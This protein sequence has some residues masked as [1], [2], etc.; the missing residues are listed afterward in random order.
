MIDSLIQR[1]RA[2]MAEIPQ[3]AVERVSRALNNTDSSSCTGPSKPCP[4]SVSSAIGHVL[5]GATYEGTTSLVLPCG[6]R[7]ADTI[8]FLGGQSSEELPGALPL[9]PLPFPD[10]S[11]DSVF[12][13]MEAAH[14]RCPELSRSRSATPLRLLLKECVRVLKPGGCLVLTAPNRNS[15]WR[16]LRSATNPLQPKPQ[17]PARTKGGYTRLLHSAGFSGVEHYI[18]WPDPSAWRQLI[19]VDNFIGHA[20]FR[21]PGTALKQKVGKAMFMLL[22]RLGFAAEFVA[23]YCII[24]IKPVVD[25]AFDALPSTLDL[26][27][28]SAGTRG[29]SS[30]S[31]LDF[32]GSSN[33]IVFKVD[34]RFFKVP[35]SSGSAT[36]L[37][38]EAEMVA[39]A[40]ELDPALSTL[41]LPSEF[42]SVAGAGFAVFPHIQLH[43]TGSWDE[44]VER[45]SYALERLALE[46][47]P[48]PLSETD[49]W[50]RLF[51]EEMLQDFAALGAG[52]LLAD[53]QRRSAM[54]TAPAGIVHGDLVYHNVICDKRD[55]RLF[56][57]DWSQG[58]RHSPKFL[59][60]VRA[61]YAIARRQY[62]SRNHGKTNSEEILGAWNL[63]VAGEPGNPLY[64]Y[65]EAASGE[66]TWKE[67]LAVAFLDR[68][69]RDLWA[70]RSNEGFRSPV[71][72]MLRTRLDLVRHCLQVPHLRSP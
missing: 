70:L 28:R 30:I 26:I 8:H 36:L 13:D 50:R 20:D 63:L 31:H 43:Y 46:G 17:P 47:R 9:R 57:I 16:L 72:T 51:D 4:A 67:T 49:L 66:L 39:H 35:L 60:A 37:Q 56:L 55:G 65:V 1:V 53:L 10:D 61:S 34:S 6:G 18:P 69:A 22:K 14:L 21:F 2:G 19:R 24:A 41:T 54:L 38:T 52:D 45:L 32:R 7:I 3:F 12:L 40:A 29:A 25:S 15:L 48:M 64:P 5:L 23:S 59:D 71:E 33:S 44:S 27:A 11:F 42:L 58:E 68:I 62:A